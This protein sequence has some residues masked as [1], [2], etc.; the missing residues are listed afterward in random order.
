[1]FGTLSS[2][3]LRNLLTT[4]TLVSIVLATI[5][6]LTQSMKF[7]ELVLSSGAASS[8]FWLLTLL[9]LPRFLEVI[10]PIS[11]AVSVIFIYVR[12]MSDNELAVLRSNGLSP[13]RLA[14]PPLILATFL[15]VLLWLMTLWLTPESMRKVEFMQTKLKSEFSTVLFQ[16]G[17]FNRFGNDIT[18]FIRDRGPDGE[19]RGLIVHDKRDRNPH[20]VT[21]T[22][23]S[24]K[25]T[26]TADGKTQITVFDGSRQDFDPKTQI[27]NR[28]DFE[29]YK[30]DLPGSAAITDKWR[31]AYERTT[32]ELLS[33]NLEDSR[34][35]DNL[36]QF[37]IELHR[38]I[39]SPLLTFTF[40]F[41]VLPV[42]LLGTYGRQGSFK[43]VMGASLAVLLLQALYLT[44][45]N[46][47]KKHEMAG[48]LSMYILI[49]API[50]AGTLLMSRHGEALRSF[51][52]YRRA[53]V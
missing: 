38:R 44:G 39:L 27:L 3:I 17:V 21:I 15:V 37:R 52:F 4:L 51:I 36:S 13:L 46:I 23:R 7:L 45:L 22:A 28:L 33:P 14:T 49:F 20:P 16:E 53:A 18:V 5:I 12:M 6:F 34:D 48:L 47:T 25:V 29:R 42:L 35:A 10:L 24:G 41:T 9:V 11:M 30:I 1:M 50:L 19:L 2:Y 43:R 8:T 26:T 40:L 31:D 32:P